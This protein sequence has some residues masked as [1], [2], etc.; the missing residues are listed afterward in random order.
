MALTPARLL[1]YDGIAVHVGHEDVW[2]FDGAVG[3]LVVFEDCEIGAAYG[4]A[5]AV[6]GVEEFALLCARGTIADVGAASL[7]GFEVRAGGDLAVEVLAREPDFEVV[8]F[9]GRE[10]HVAGA[11]EHAAVGKA[12]L[13]EHGFGVA[14]EGFVF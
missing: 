11:E 14:G 12:E 9:G 4:E 6:E 10:A 5:A 2:N 3:L 7:E 8:S 1:A 13:F